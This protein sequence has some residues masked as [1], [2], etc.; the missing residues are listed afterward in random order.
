MWK[1]YHVHEVQM[2]GNSNSQKFNVGSFACST[3]ST[4]VVWDGRQKNILVRLSQM[5]L[6]LLLIKYAVIDLYSATQLDRNQC[7]TYLQ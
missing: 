5:S 7:S 4:L 6:W 2:T 1:L 3:V